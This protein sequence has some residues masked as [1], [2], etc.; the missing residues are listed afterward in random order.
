ML[1][2]LGRDYPDYWH[3]RRSDVQ[4]LESSLQRVQEIRDRLS[5]TENAKDMPAFLDWFDGW[6]LKRG[7]P[8]EANP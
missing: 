6:F 3:L 1:R 5:L 7:R 4:S 2:E 8:Q